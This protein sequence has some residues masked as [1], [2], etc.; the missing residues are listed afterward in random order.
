[1]PATV[2]CF[3]SYRSQRAR[4]GARDMANEAAATTSPFQ[5]RLA[6]AL[7]PRQISHRRTMLDYA[8][9]LRMTAVS[10]ISRRASR[11]GSLASASWMRSIGSV[12]GSL[13]SRND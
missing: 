8:R 3:E 4:Q 2:I 10:P 1:M 9:Q 7:S 13:L 6:V 11:S 5:D 12:N